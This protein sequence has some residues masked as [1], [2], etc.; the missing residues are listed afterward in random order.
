MHKWHIWSKAGVDFGVHEGVT[1]SEAL[2]SLI[3]DA[4]YGDKQVWLE[5]DSLCYQDEGYREMC[6]DVN[7]WTFEEVV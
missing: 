7:D 3:R 1:K 6:G 4:D 2:L 5:G